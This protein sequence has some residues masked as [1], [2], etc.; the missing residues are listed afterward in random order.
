MTGKSRGG[1]FARRLADMA[2]HPAQ[3]GYRPPPAN[4]CFTGTYTIWPMGTQ[5]DVHAVAVR[6][7]VYQGLY[8]DFSL[9]QI[10]V[11]DGI[12]RAVARIDCCHS[13][14]HRHQFNQEGTDLLRGEVICEIPAEGGV[15]VVHNHYQPCLDIMDDEWED[16]FRRWAMAE[17]NPERTAAFDFA[18]RLADREFRD[19]LRQLGASES[20]DVVVALDETP[21]TEVFDRV[22]TRTRPPAVIAIRRA[23][24]RLGFVFMV[25]SPGIR[26]EDESGHRDVSAVGATTS[27]GMLHDALAADGDE[28][29]DVGPRWNY[30][31]QPF[32]P[33]A[34][35]A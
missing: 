32:R 18:S 6:Y 20:Q 1:R 27:I 21:V 10:C 25:V 14:I 23:V 4:Q 33:H 17:H 9:N 5:N 28:S 24:A 22:F 3:R 8:V 19:V 26:S 35:T 12:S 31:I 13:T 29:F 7:A 16:N 34:T 11:V 2:I 15:K 30:T